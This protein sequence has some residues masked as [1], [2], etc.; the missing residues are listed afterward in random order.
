MDVGD[1]LGRPG[2]TTGCR[3]IYDDDIVDWCMLS[4][5]VHDFTYLFVMVQKIGHS[6]GN[7]LAMPLTWF[8]VYRR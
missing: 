7:V 2:P 5:F 1:F 4:I 6:Q 3:A 8:Y